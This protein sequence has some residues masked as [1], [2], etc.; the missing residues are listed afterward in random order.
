MFSS[1]FFWSGIMK[2]HYPFNGKIRSYW[3]S[4]SLLIYFSRRQE[5]L[6]QNPLASPLSKVNPG[7]PVQR[8]PIELKPQPE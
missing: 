6:P 8:K 7:I 3:Q 4:N 2:I 1:D 5:E